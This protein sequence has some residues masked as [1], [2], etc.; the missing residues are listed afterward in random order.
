MENPEDIVGHKTFS[1]GEICPQ[2]GLPALR[3]EPLMRCEAEAMMALADVAQSKREIEMPDEN[4]AIH[5]MWDGWYRLKDFGW[6]EACYCPKDGTHFQVIEA[7]STGIHDCAYQG[8]WAS[9][10][11]WIYGDGDIWP[12]RPVLFKLYP[13]DQEKYEAKM[14]AAAERFRAEM[15][16]ES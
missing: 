1:T 3:H 8:E 13:E 10:S 9:G 7:G 11:W 14:K 12:S 4:S 6:R 2:T 16:A 5:H 15:D